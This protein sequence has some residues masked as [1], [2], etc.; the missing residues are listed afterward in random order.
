VH[1]DRN[2]R[3]RLYTRGRTGRCNPYAHEPAIPSPSVASMYVDS[4]DRLW[5]GLWGGLYVV[6]RENGVFRQVHGRRSVWNDEAR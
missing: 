6:Y 2:E 5:I 1:L 4:S 3:A